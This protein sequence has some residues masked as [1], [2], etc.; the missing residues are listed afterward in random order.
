VNEEMDGAVPRIRAG[1]C[2]AEHRRRLV[3]RDAPILCCTAEVLANIALREGTRAKVGDVIMDE[4]HYY[5]D[6]SA[7]RRGRCRCSR[8]RRRASS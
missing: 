5:A 8:C 3:N 2:G 1:E 4:F 6:R 7:A